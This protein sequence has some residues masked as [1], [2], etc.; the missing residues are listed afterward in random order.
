MKLKNVV[1]KIASLFLAAFLTLVDPAFAL[2]TEQSVDSGL[3][4]EIVRSLGGPLEPSAGLEEVE[5]Q[6]LIGFLS[7]M[8]RIAA[9]RDWSASLEDPPQL[10]GELVDKDPKLSREAVRILNETV[11]SVY[12]VLHS[13]LPDDRDTQMYLRM[14]Q[15]VAARYLMSTGQFTESAALAFSKDPLSLQG[16]V[17]YRQWK[18]WLERAESADGNGHPL[19]TTEWV[20]RATHHH[21]A[22]LLLLLTSSRKQFLDPK[23]LNDALKVFSEE[24]HHQLEMEPRHVKRPTVELGTVVKQIREL[25]RQIKVPP[26]VKKA[27][28]MDNAPTV[29]ELTAIVGQISG[30]VAHQLGYHAWADDFART[31]KEIYAGLLKGHPDYV[32]WQPYPPAAGLEEGTLSGFSPEEEELLRKFGL[33]TRTLSALRDAG[34]TSIEELDNEPLGELRL[35]RGGGKVG[36]RQIKKARDL[37]RARLR[38]SV[39]PGVKAKPFELIARYESFMARAG[40][41]VKWLERKGVPRTLEAVRGMLDEERFDRDGALVEL[42][43][44]RGLL[45]E[46]GGTIPGMDTPQRFLSEA[47]EVLTAAGLEEGLTVDEATE[48]FRHVSVRDAQGQGI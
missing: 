25:L 11:E 1:S 24:L 27:I 34:I 15:A 9:E 48:V 17:W 13:E 47:I 33:T 16:D 10:F 30:K 44:I 45:Q 2:R 42:R 14:I 46:Y 5:E 8:N 26:E 38:Q 12:R 39:T 23:D 35:L 7:E 28:L 18:I 20:P 41:S 37:I 32:P 19:K 22:L 4:E 43:R 29:I 6:K 36:F 40:S 31:S 3:E 21:V